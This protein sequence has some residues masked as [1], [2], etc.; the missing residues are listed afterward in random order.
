MWRDDEISFAMLKLSCL[1]SFWVETSSK[2]V[3]P[4][5]QS[6]GKHIDIIGLFGVDPGYSERGLGW[7]YPGPQLQWSLSWELWA[8]TGKNVK[9][10]RG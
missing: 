3:T 6:L 5:I 10:K 1:W 2:Q 7:A 4:W 9:R 8:H